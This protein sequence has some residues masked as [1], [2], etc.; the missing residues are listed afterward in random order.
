MM[1]GKYTRPAAATLLAILPLTVSAQTA[2]TNFDVRI[3]I[4]AECRI[5]AA[6]P[7]DFGS[8]G[9]LAANVDVATSMQVVCTNTTP[10]NIGLN[11]GSTAG[12]TTTTR[13]M[14]S[15]T[16]TV[17]YQL[18]RDA[19]HTLNWGTTVGTNTLASTGTGNTQTF[20]IYGRVI[21]QATPAPGNYTDNVT[22]T[23]T[24]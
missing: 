9:V 5:V 3:T 7:L 1:F 10:Y 22:V 19:G 24:Y 20:P 15:G 21:P 14:T 18:F 11:G 23:V 2:T 4:A 8:A 6:N 13:L 17:A 12:G 16:A